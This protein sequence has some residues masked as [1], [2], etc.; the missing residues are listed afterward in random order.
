M[1]GESTRELYADQDSGVASGLAQRAY[2]PK[3]I[4]RWLGQ[5][6]PSRLKGSV[7]VPVVVLTEER[8]PSR[9]S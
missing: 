6:V 8:E 5:D 2:G 1:T 7:M 3:R 4:A 9:T